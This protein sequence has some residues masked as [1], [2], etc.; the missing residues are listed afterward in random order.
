MKNY[1]RPPLPFVGSKLRWWRQLQS[2]ARQFSF[3]DC[4]FDAFGGSL[5]VARVMKD[6]C[7]HL[8]V[9]T[10]DFQHAYRRRLSL[11]RET[12][13]VYEKLVAEIPFAKNYRSHSA[14]YRDMRFES[15]DEKKRAIAIIEQAEDIETA[16]RWLHG[17]AYPL[18]KIPMSNPID[19]ARCDEWTRGLIVIDE[20]LGAEDARYWAESGAFIILDPPYA[21]GS[22]LGFDAETTYSGDKNAAQDFCAAVMARTPR[23][24]LFER[25]ESAL[26]NFARKLG[27]ITIE[28]TNTR[29]HNTVNE[30]MMICSS[31]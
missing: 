2:L 1:R 3:G 22:K 12:F 11:A 4:I 30:V 7:S 5:S 25:R 28:R 14:P 17:R 8:S 10:N 31:I 21:K 26:A 20:A 16:W 15:D 27:A 13:K 9:I 29:N 6:E 19:P 18:K 24:C 23:W